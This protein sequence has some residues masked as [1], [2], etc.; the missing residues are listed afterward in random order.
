MTPQALL[1]AGI[2]CASEPVPVEPRRAVMC[3]LR[4]LECGGDS[5]QLVT[6]G[7]WKVKCHQPGQVGA[8]EAGANHH[9]FSTNMSHG[10]TEQKKQL[11]V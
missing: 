10:E 6:T 11:S 2:T 9:T 3:S 4:L 1:A 8:A 5:F 7:S